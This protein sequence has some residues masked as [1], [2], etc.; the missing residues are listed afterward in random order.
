[1]K[2]SPMAHLCQVQIRE[3]SPKYKNEE[4]RKCINFHNYG[5]DWF[6]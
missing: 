1:M 3:I 6:V 4:D 5:S 2:K